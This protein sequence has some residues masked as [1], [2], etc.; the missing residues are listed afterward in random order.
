MV[1]EKACRV[2]TLGSQT[3]EGILKG[4]MSLSSTEVVHD[5]TEVLNKIK[6]CMESN[7]HMRI[8]YSQISYLKTRKL[9]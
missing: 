4:K 5:L 9:S 6:Y 7:K 8:S 3:E 2:K 1:H